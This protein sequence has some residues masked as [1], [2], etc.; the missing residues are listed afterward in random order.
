MINISFSKKILTT[1]T[2][3]I[4]K[5]KT[6]QRGF[7]IGKFKDERGTECS[8]QKSSSAEKECI[9]LGAK[10]IGL[11]EFV[12]YGNPAWKDRDEFD[13]HTMEHHFSANTRMHLTRNQVKKLIPILQKFVDTGDIF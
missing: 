6:T 5:I 8:I 4:M 3:A 10:K 2:K 12:A 11:K 13:E 9:W 7:A 1:H